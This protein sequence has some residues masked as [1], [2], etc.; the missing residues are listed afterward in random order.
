MPDRRLKPLVWVA[1]SRDDLRALPDAVQDRIGYA[2]YQA[3]IGL[4][5]RDA[6]PLAGFGSEVFEVTHRF[7][8]ATYRTVYTVGFADAVYALHVFQKKSKK[9]IAT[10]AFE[11]ALLKR[12]L[13]AA[14]EHY[15]ATYGERTRR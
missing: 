15:R 10:P 9:G 13:R 2:L 3:Q 11:I 7:A 12:R 4:K 1:S 14:E 6:K 5:H 8:S